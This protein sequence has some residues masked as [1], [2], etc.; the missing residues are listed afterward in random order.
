MGMTIMRILSG[1]MTFRIVISMLAG[2]LVGAIGCRSGFNP[3]AMDLDP[4]DVTY[5]GNDVKAGKVSA[6]DVA[7]GQQ[8]PGGSAERG[9]ATLSN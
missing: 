2:L 7:V 6:A 5:Y 9:T 4:A 3:A 8:M 1:K